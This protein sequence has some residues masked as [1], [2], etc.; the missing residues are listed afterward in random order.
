MKREIN[1]F[2]TVIKHF[3]KSFSPMDMENV[4]HLDAKKK[5][6]LHLGVMTYLILTKNS[7]KLP[8]TKLYSNA[9]CFYQ[10]IPYAI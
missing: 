6:H 1:I 7:R 4:E 8:G 10:D 3:H 5:T 2:R 9:Q